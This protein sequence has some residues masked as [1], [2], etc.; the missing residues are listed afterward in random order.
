MMASVNTLRAAIRNLD[1]KLMELQSNRKQFNHYVSQQKTGLTA[2]GEAVPELL[3]NLFEAYLGASDE[4]FVE[5]I[6]IRQYS[7]IDGSAPLTTDKLMA[8]ALAQYEYYVDQGTWNA[9]TKKDRKI[10]ALTTE[11]NKLQKVHK[12]G[13]SF[14]K[15]PR[16]NDDKYAWKKNKPSGKER[17]KVLGKK[18]YNWCKWHQ[19]WVIHDPT[20]CILANKVKEDKPKEDGVNRADAKMKALMIDPALQAEIYTDSDAD[21]EFK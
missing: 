3:M 18:S 2:R 17:T 5:Y 20:K 9:P 7:H 6:W 13:E 10:I 1:K 12:V 15:K 11:V 4:S 19:A 21:Y 16:R 8:L 14:S